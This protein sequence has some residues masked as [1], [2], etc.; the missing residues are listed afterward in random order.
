MDGRRWPVWLAALFVLLGLGLVRVATDAEF[1]FVS[2]S[3]LP[4]LCGAW[5][6]GRRAGLG[7]A[8]LAA[9][10]WLVGDL[11]SSRVP[12]A[13]WTHELNAAIHLL[14]YGVAAALASGLRERLDRA[15]EHAFR[16]ELTRL[17]NRR[18]FHA[19]GEQALERARRARTALTIVFVDLDNFKLV[20]DRDGH[21]T[22]DAALRA[23]AQA[24]HQAARDGDL[25]ARIGGDEFALL[26]TGVDR[27][28]AA[29]AGDRLLGAARAALQ[30][31]E[32]LSASVGVAW[33]GCADRRLD[34]LLATAD[35]LMLRAKRGGKDAVVFEAFA[36]TQ[37]MPA[38]AP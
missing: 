38:A 13:A 22:G 18:A 9:A 6:L 17:F 16:D 21:G 37:A 26:L 10:M 8:A 2:L 32:G 19:L 31:F 20:N 34:E 11:V 29:L 7:L 36:A 23:A 28:A 27:A 24:L 12:A 3:L 33:F 14:T 5:F 4:V 30:G 1:V 25:L 15:R 35:A